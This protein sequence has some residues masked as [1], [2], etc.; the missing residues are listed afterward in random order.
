[1]ARL[2]LTARTAP[3][4]E[5]VAA[6]CRARGAEVIVVPADLSQPHGAGGLLAALEARDIAV[7]HLVNNAG[8]STHGRVAEADAE[9]QL[10]VIDVNAR[11]PLELATRLLPG[12][13]SRRRGGVLNIAST[14]AF[15]GTAWMAVYAGTKAC[16]LTWSEALH[17]ELRGTGV[18]CTC[19]CPGPV[20]TG[21]FRRNH[22]PGEPPAFVL[23]TPV[24][25]AES[26]LRAYVNDRSHAV[27]ALLPRLGAWGTRLLPRAVVARMAAGYARP[28][29]M[30]RA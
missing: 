23:E 21:F 13:I 2:V 3:A 22:F 20:G 4:L 26:A 6:L 16:L 15:Q 9:A 1:V 17:V 28:G 11:A 24:H 25:A 27:T 7:D 18:R 5:E 19:A 14:S 29:G 8:F 30:G 12:M 10:A